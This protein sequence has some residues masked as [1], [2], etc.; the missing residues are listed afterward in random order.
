MGR[1][2]IVSA[3]KQRDATWLNNLLKQIE[4][5]PHLIEARKIIGVDDLGGPIYAEP[6]LGPAQ[7]NT[8]FITSGRLHRP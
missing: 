2:R 3:E 7:P 1:G 6:D 4:K 8:F 5:Y